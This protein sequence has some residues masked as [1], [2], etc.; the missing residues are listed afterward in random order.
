[1][2]ENNDQTA[3]ARLGGV[4]LGSTDP[5]RL[6]AWYRAAFA[7]EAEPGGPG[8][9]LEVGGSTLIFERRDDVAPKAAEPGRALLTFQVD[10]IKAAAARLDELGVRWIRPVSDPAPGDPVVLATVEDPDGNY[11]QILQALNG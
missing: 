8:L 7:P 11:P 9:V 2:T 4:V 10:D 6:H 5:E 3:T 1:M